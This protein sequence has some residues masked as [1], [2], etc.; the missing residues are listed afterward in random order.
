MARVFEATT[1][2]GKI[3]G[4]C[5]IAAAVKIQRSQSVGTDDIENICVFNTHH[6][7]YNGETTPVI[8]TVEATQGCLPVAD[9]KRNSSR[10]PQGELSK[11]RE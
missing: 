7:S 11:E 1:T 5:L 9:N 10:A 8:H 6:H 4:G 3:H 2:L